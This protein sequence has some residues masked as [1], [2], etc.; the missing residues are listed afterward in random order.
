MLNPEEFKLFQNHPNPFNPSTN[1]RF[2]V[3]NSAF[4]SLKIFDALGNE[5]ATLVSEE[6]QPGNYEV[7]FNSGTV[8]NLSSG[9]Y[10]YTL[11]AGRYSETKKM[12]LLR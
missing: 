3:S 8:P 11:R 2:Q 4:V 7:K 12:I 5:V 10:F 1:I 9:I 6:K